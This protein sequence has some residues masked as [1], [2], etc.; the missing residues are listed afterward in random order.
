MFKKG[1]AMVLASF[2]GDSLALGAHWIY[3]TAVIDERIGRVDRLLE[4]L[5]DSYHRGKK[6]GDFTHYGDQA[7]VLLES[8]ARNRG[9]VLQGFAEDW[10]RLFS[11][12]RGYV[13]KATSRT[14]ENFAAGAAPENSGSGSADLGGAARIAPLVYLYREQPEQLLE[15]S[16]AQTRMTHTAP[17]AVAAAE[18]L[19]RVTYSVLHGIVPTAAIEDAIDAGVSDMDLDM[20]L[21]GA[22]EITSTDSREVIAGLGQ[23]CGA[24]NALPAAVHLI[25]THEHDLERALIENSMAGGDSAGRGL[26]VGMV[27]GAHLGMEAIPTHWLEEMRS[28]Q[29]IVELLEQ[30]P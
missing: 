18:F 5:D 7:L 11:S 26:A 6:K 3:D 15:S 19:A 8:I 22:M 9:F 29:H 25:I 28:Y 23:M 10:Q 4:P 1:K 24:A 12:Y 14:L 27:L 30:V 20:R 17:S 16:V 2:A 13:D 21:R